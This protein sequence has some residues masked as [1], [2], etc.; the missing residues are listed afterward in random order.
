MKKFLT[1]MGLLTIVAT[2]LTIVA[3]PASAQAY[4]QCWGTGNVSDQPKLEKI[5]GAYGYAMS[6]PSQDGAATIV[7]HPQVFAPERKHLMMRA[8]AKSQ[9]S[10]TRNKTR[11]ETRVISMALN[12]NLPKESQTF[13]MAELH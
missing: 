4:C 2:P 3:K 7:H 13:F 6:V 12:R 1:I 11:S 8:C 5:N 10:R 9:N